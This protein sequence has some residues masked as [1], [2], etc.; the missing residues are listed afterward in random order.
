MKPWRPGPRQASARSAPRFAPAAPAPLALHLLYVLNT[1]FVGPEFSLLWVPSSLPCPHG[2]Q[3][4]TKRHS[5]GRPLLSPRSLCLFP[6][7]E[8]RESSGNAGLGFGIRVTRAPYTTSRLGSGRFG[9]KVLCWTPQMAPSLSSEAQGVGRGP[10]QA[11]LQNPLAAGP[12][13]REIRGS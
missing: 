9:S 4:P 6:H 13:V 5:R 12:E 10:R 8:V 2:S 7:W 3:L 11:G 1:R